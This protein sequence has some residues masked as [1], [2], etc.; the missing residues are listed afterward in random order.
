MNKMYPEIEEGRD[1]PFLGGSQVSNA[2]PHGAP[3]QAGAPI[4][5]FLCSVVATKETALSSAVSHISRKTSEMWGTRSLLP[6]RTMQ[7]LGICE[8]PYRG[9]AKV[10][11]SLPEAMATYC[12]PLTA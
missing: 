8:F 9:K 2:R 1:W 4:A 5:F 3:G 11:R 12:V 10:K 6:V 7:I